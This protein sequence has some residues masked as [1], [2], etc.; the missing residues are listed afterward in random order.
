MEQERANGTSL[1]IYSYIGSVDLNDCW[2][3]RI[4]SLGCLFHASFPIYNSVTLY[5]LETDKV[6]MHSL[7]L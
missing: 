4:L 2:Y 7:S 1:G 3:V 5:S 6:E